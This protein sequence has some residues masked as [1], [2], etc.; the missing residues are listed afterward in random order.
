VKW[1]TAVLMSQVSLKEATTHSVGQAI[2]CVLPKP[3]FHYCAYS[4]LLLG[5][6]MVIWR[7]CQ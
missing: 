3:E 1:Y 5:S 7:H 6:I 4:S 2:P